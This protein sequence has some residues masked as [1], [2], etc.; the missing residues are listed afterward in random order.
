MP[1]ALAY[2]TSSIPLLKNC[3]TAAA[4]QMPIHVRI[5]LLRLGFILFPR[6]AV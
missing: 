4:S 2:P 3:T 1:S 5:A 6:F